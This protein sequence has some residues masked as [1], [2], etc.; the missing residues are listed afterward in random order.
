[1]RAF[2]CRL[3]L[4]R[5]LTT[6]GRRRVK[7]HQMAYYRRAIDGCMNINRDSAHEIEHLP[8]LFDT[9]AL[10][11]E[12]PGFLSDNQNSEDFSEDDLGRRYSGGP[13]RTLSR[14]LASTSGEESKPEEESV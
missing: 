9:N 3:S 6:A 13:R 8:H 10:Q 5:R 14:V 11:F 2:Y 12:D 7:E 4:C 1:M